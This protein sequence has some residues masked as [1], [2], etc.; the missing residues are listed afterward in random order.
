MPTLTPL[1]SPEVLNQFCLEARA[2]LLELA[3]TFDRID[4]GEGFDA[5]DPRLGLLRQALHVLNQS[6]EQSIPYRAEQLQ[7]LFSRKYDPQWLKDFTPTR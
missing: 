6:M 3:A 1:S 5:N 7:L 4:R 2:K